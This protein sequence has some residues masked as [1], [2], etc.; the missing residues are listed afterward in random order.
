MKTNDIKSITA[1]MYQNI[2]SFGDDSSRRQQS[3]QFNI[4]K[5]CI[6]QRQNDEM[7]FTVVACFFMLLLSALT[8]NSISNIKDLMQTTLETNLLVDE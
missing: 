1:R 2:L 8:Q 5:Q 6:E 3:L 7:F 4:W